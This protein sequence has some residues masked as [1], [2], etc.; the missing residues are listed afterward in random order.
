VISS[1]G[2]DSND[3]SSISLF[4]S[5]DNIINDNLM[6]SSLNEIFVD[7]KSTNTSL[8]SNHFTR[9]F[10]VDINIGKWGKI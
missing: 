6:L 1:N 7:T 9:S 10:G 2:F 5:H 4:G 8:T 3:I